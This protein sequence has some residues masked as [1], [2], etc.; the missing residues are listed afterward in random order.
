MPLSVFYH[1]L[2]KAKVYIKAKQYFNHNPSITIV[3]FI[4]NAICITFV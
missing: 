2:N 3:N 4:N 1:T